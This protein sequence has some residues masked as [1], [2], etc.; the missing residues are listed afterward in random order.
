M[1]GM[2]WNRMAW[3]GMG[4]IVGG[5]HRCGV[6]NHRNIAQAAEATG[7]RRRRR[8]AIPFPRH[9]AHSYKPRFRP[10]LSAPF[11][12]ARLATLQMQI[13]RYRY[14]NRDYSRLQMRMQMQIYG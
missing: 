6:Q 3:D 1:D 7:Y 8:L 14:R 12:G 13:Y 9:F 10:D 5:T 11:C 4:W 2:G